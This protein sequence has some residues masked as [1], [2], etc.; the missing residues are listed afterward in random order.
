MYM[1]YKFAYQVDALPWKI[2]GVSHHSSNRKSQSQWNPYDILA[3]IGCCDVIGGYLGMH[4]RKWWSTDETPWFSM[5]IYTLCIYIMSHSL[6][7]FVNLNYHTPSMSYHVLFPTDISNSHVSILQYIKQYIDG[8]H[9]GLVRNMILLEVSKT[10]SMAPTHIE[11][12]R[13]RK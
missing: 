1:F 5:I 11:P 3:P 10:G 4:Y 12:T 13:K 9:H 2:S 7:I 8:N 6:I